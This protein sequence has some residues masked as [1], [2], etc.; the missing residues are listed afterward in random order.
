MAGRHRSDD[1]TRGEETP[2]PD[3]SSTAERTATDW[4]RHRVDSDDDDDDDDDDLCSNY[5]RDMRLF[6]RVSTPVYSCSA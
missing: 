4:R 6:E 2:P 3:V 5:K 1:V